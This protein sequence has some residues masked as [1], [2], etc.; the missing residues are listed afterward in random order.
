M[1]NLSQS[2]VRLVFN[3]SR[4]VAEVDV[5]G[6]PVSDLFKLWLGEYVKDGDL[7]TLARCHVDAHTFISG[8]PYV[9]IDGDHK[10]FF[11]DRNEGFEQS[12]IRY[13]IN[14]N[15]AIA[16]SIRSQLFNADG[17]F[18][19][20]AKAM[21][22]PI[23]NEDNGQS[24]LSGY[25][26]VVY[27]VDREA[28]VRLD[29]DGWQVVDIDPNQISHIQ[30]ITRGHADFS[31]RRKTV[32]LGMMLQAQFQQFG[33]S[34]TKPATVADTR[35]ALLTLNKPAEGRRRNHKKN[36]SKTMED[37]M[38]KVQPQPQPTNSDL[39]TISEVKRTTD[40]AALDLLNQITGTKASDL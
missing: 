23:L 11:Q 26:L 24:M 14:F 15:G 27:V 37:L 13:N 1:S 40:S 34:S 31:T 17:S 4:L 22:N 10:F 18:T 25:Q 38:A 8:V 32:D 33:S 7:K 12:L 36:P 3:V 20:M 21:A 35:D 39:P 19:D 28:D 16:E 5:N 30:V 9:A 6:N 29:K 2:A